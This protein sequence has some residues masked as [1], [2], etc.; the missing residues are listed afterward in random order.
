MATLQKS[1]KRKKEAIIQ[2][3]LEAGIPLTNDEPPADYRLGLSNTK[4]F[5]GDRKSPDVTSLQD[6][7]D[8]TNENEKIRLHYDKKSIGFCVMLLDVKKRKS[9]DEWITTIK[10]DQ[11]SD[12]Y[13][14]LKTS[15]KKHGWGLI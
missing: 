9:E 15:L 3:I 12:N 13:E 2:P 14:E 1:F 7:I 11:K 10:L 8:R 6:C 5:R 4:P